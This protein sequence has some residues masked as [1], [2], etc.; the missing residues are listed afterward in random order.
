MNG[1]WMIAS[2]GLP[3]EAHGLHLMAIDRGPL[4]VSSAFLVH[5]GQPISFFRV[6]CGIRSDQRKPDGPKWEQ[7][8]DAAMGSGRLG[9]CSST[10]ALLLTDFFERFGIHSFQFKS[11]SSMC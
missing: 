10:G 5:H 6:I 8:G 2:L 9:T 3:N 7:P 4:N 11:S 1:L